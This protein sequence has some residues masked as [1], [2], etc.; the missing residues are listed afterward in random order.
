M[1]EKPYSVVGYDFDRLVALLAEHSDPKYVLSKTHSV[2]FEGYFRELN[3]KTI[4]VEEK[5]VDHDYLEDFAAYY[6]RCFHRYPRQ[7]RR[8]HFFAVEFDHKAF[9][10]VLRGE[11]ADLPISLRDR[12]LGF[13]VVKPLP[14]TLVG[15]TCLKTYPPDGGRRQFP[16]L[17]EYTAN[18]FGLALSVKTLAFQEQDSV[19][20]ACAT[21]ALWSVFQGTGQIFHHWLPSPAE[22]TRN[23]VD[24]IPEEL[25]PYS[26]PETRGM[27]NKGLT[28]SQMARAIRAVGLESYLLGASNPSELRATAYAYLRA[29]IPMILVFSLKDVTQKE[30]ERAIGRHGVAITGFSLAPEAPPSLPKGQFNLKAYRIDKLY[31]HDDQVGPFAR[32]VFQESGRL[33]TSWCIRQG[34]TVEAEAQFL[35]IPIY[36]KIRIPYASIQQAIRTIG[37][38]ID[39]LLANV[40]PQADYSIEWDIFLTTVNTLKAELLATPGVKPEVREAFLSRSLPKYL[41]RAT[42]SLNDAAEAD[43][44]FDATDIEQRG[45]FLGAVEY[46][47]NIVGLLRLLATAPVA[48]TVGGIAG[49]ILAHFGTA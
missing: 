1:S 37:S 33:N 38:I 27:P 34:K 25:H 7:T 45:G 15:R 13:V 39:N 4:V 36:H 28:A 23:A 40:A 2:Y 46:R 35:L 24:H 9:A 48:Q 29:R 43:L 20:S 3:A 31:V 41:W 22:I 18:L 16:I 11:N 19:V 47:P 5:Y 42:V 21:S 10:A 8:L 12:Y 6:V 30:T 14:Q 44:L 49:C 26:L 17:Q 32:M